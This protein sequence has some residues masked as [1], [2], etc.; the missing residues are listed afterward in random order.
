M[1]VTT[2]NGIIR[3]TV[4]ADVFTGPMTVTSIAIMSSSN[5]LGGTVP[6]QDS[7]TNVLFIANVLPDDMRII[8]FP[9]GKNFQNGVRLG[10]MTNVSEVVFFLK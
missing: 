7:D 3:M 1:A 5:V 2:K 6:I 4:A 10:T 8:E 9:G